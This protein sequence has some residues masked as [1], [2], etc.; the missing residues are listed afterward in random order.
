MNDRIFQKKL[1]NIFAVAVFA[2]SALSM[3]ACS[4]DKYD[5]DPYF[6]IEDQVSGLTVDAGGITK[7]DRKVYT[8][9]S[10]RPWKIAQSAENDWL[11]I[12]ADEGADDGLFYIWADKNETFDA[13]SANLIFT[14]NGQEQPVMFRVDQKADVPTVSIENA[15]DG[16]EILGSGGRLKVP[17][18]N[19]V[20]WT[21]SLAQNDW[22]VIDSVKNDTVYITA[23]RNTTDDPRSVVL[24]AAGTGTYSVLTSSTVISQPTFGIIMNEHFDWMQEGTTI[25]SE[26]DYGYYQGGELSFASWNSAEK[27][28]GWETITEN[29][30]STTPS[31]YGGH[32]YLKFGRT[33]FAGNI[34]SPALSGITGTMD[35][36]VTFKCIGYVSSTGTKDDNIVKVLVYKGGGTLVGETTTFYANTDGTSDAFDA[37]TLNVP[38]YPNSSKQENGADYNPW[39]Q[40]GVTLTFDITGATKDTRF[41]FVSGTAWGSALKGKGQGKNRLYVDDVKVTVIN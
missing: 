19:N 28:H 41:M 39:K 17:V 36:R 3:V 33:N 26:T 25:T 1:L 24:T 29:A 34:L 37:L 9:R 18:T 6:Y 2:V 40:E 21:A 7:T 5:G 11:H 23:Q 14:V 31:L 38:V 8:I 35:V 15:T 20:D 22:A 13:R 10:N 4:S 27:S 30:G 12:F 16:Y 32:G